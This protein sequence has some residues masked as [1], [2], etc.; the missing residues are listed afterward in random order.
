MRKYVLN[1]NTGVI[2]IYEDLHY[3]PVY[4]VEKASACGDPP[5]LFNSYDL[6]E[7]ATDQ[8][9][10]LKARKHH[11]TMQ[12]RFCQKCFPLT[13]TFLDIYVQDLRPPRY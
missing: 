6:G 4:G 5:A 12:L 8:L 9:A 11:P 10:G 13:A 3:N 7:C 1:T 2:H